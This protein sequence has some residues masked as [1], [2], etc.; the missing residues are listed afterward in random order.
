MGSFFLRS[1][2][3]RVA[4]ILALFLLVQTSASEGRAQDDEELV[5]ARAKFQ[6]ALEL[7]QAENFAGA[8]VLYREVGAVK[9]TPQV[10][11]H[12]ALCEEKLGQLVSALGG[13]EL[14][15]TMGTDMPED[16]VAEVQTSIDELRARIPKLIIRR[17]EGAE[18]ASISLDGVLL[19][20]ASIGSEIPLNPGP[21]TVFA[22]SRGYEDYQQTV[23]MTA[24][25]T[26][27]LSITM[28]EIVVPE[29]EKP[30]VVPAKKEPRFGV[31]PYVIAGTGL[32]TAITGGVL[33]GVSQL[34][35]AKIKDICG[36]F[37]CSTVD[38]SSKDRARELERSAR[39]LEV[40][41]W[42]TL[43]FGLAAT[44]AGAIM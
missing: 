26:E 25:S 43:G 7:E 39:G 24:G 14:A 18:A 38:D 13:Y 1:L 16:F 23:S 15:M 27:T 35:V 20:Q 36:D 40:A 41:G 33:L 2:A 37:D 28:D 29:P 21:H 5:E 3:S 6:R 22:Q 8:L 44:G 10:R 4:I 32:G 31:A 9:M 19:G 17:G 30:P 42:V 12:I 11:Y 34:K